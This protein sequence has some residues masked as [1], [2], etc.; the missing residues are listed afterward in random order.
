MLVT[1]ESLRVMETMP[2]AL[3]AVP[4]LR[5]SVPYQIRT[6]E[7]SNLSKSK[8]KTHDGIDIADPSSMQDACH[9]RTQ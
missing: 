8:L 3:T 1:I 9:I 5:N 7:N 6:A 4:K 2:S